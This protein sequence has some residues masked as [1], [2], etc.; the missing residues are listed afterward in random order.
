MTWGEFKEEAESQGIRDEMEIWFIN[1][2]FPDEISAH[3]Q[4]DDGEGPNEI[5]LSIT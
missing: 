3:P 1:V 2:S 4:Q 5:G